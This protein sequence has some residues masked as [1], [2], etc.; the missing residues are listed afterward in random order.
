MSNSRKKVIVRRFTGDT[1]PGY[2]P[3]SSIVREQ[4]VVDL[5]DLG[6]RIVPLALAEIKTINYVRDFNLGDAV[7][8]E[9]LLRRTFLA[10]PRNEGLWLRLTFRSGEILEGLAATD[11]SLFDAMQNDAGLHLVPP[12]T[13][14]NTQHIFVPRCAITDLH[15][16]AVITSPS[17]RRP[18]IAAADG[19]AIQEELFPIPPAPPFPPN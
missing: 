16:I 7:N 6:G 11:L 9:R 13:R 14:T 4:S 17:R 10:R 5:L 12:D 18:L 3:L 1:L 15:L 8:P 2:L 19:E